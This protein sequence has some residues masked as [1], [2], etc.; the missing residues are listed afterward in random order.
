MRH[1]LGLMGRALRMAHRLGVI[2]RLSEVPRPPKGEHRSRFLSEDEIARLL[3]ACE[4]SRNRLLAPLVTLALTTGARYS[5]LATLTWAQLD[6]EADYG[7][8]PTMRLERTKN[9]RPRTVPLMA[10]AVAALVA[11]AKPDQREGR[12]F[13]LKGSIRKAFDLALERA[14]IP[15]GHRPR[16]AGVV[17][18]VAP[19]GRQLAHDPGRVAPLRPGNPGPLRTGPDGALQ[20]S[21]DG[22]HPGRPG[23]ARGAHDISSRE[24]CRHGTCCGTIARVRARSARYQSVVQEILSF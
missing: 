19:H 21:G 10:D 17:P 6:L 22:P 11:I 5:E 8:S 18:Y 4:H 15:K 23:P 20:P 9:G 12:V 24:T 13:Q 14:G 7:L 2:D 3:D 16:V 1:E